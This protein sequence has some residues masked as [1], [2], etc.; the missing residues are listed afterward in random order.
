MKP[1]KIFGY[2][3]M[4]VASIIV[5]SALLSILYF[6]FANGLSN[7]S[8]E[9]LTSADSYEKGTITTAQLH[10]GDLQYDLTA[11]SATVTKTSGNIEFETDMQLT[12]ATEFDINRI[13][14]TPIAYLEA[15]EVDELLTS[16]E[17]LE[18]AV[19]VHKQGIL[20]MVVSTL[21]LIILS[22]LI[23]LPLGI[24]SAI[25]LIEYP[26]GDRLDRGIHFA[27]NSLTAIPSIVFGL[28]GSLFFITILGM[29]MSILTGALTV[30]IMLL[31]IL[32][33]STEEALLSV[34]NHLRSASRALGANEVQTIFK[35]VLP[36]SMPGII[37]GVILAIGRI[38][39]E[40]AILIFTAG[41]VDKLTTNP[42]ESSSTLTVKAYMLAK[43]YG[44]IGGAA[45][46][47]VVI[48]IIV[49]CLNLIAKAISH[50]F[51][52]K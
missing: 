20:S 40:S 39:G 46:V 17:N 32:I 13:N 10:P 15:E 51:E 11:S 33:R 23:A 26:I 2:G 43:E 29:P 36:S 1:R 28:F 30:S 35:V 3:L 42:L 16:G 34:P 7:I 25:Y 38:I 37:V 4:S 24:G 8:Y 44:D 47:A 31:P 27:I 49:I 52:M 22:L 14:D 45:A 9:F 19:T 12:S 6:I 5:L 18:L 41:T 21:L 48:I 50:K